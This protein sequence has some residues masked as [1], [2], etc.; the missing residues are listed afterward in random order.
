MDDTI[1]SAQRRA[2]KRYRERR[3]KSGL[4]RPEAQAPAREAAAIRKA[5]AILRERPTSAIK[6]RA[7]PGI[8]TEP[9]R[10]RSALDACAMNEPLS[11]QGEA[12]W[13][14]IMMRIERDRKDPVLNR[15]RDV[16]L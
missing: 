2:T 12:M 1:T 10:T 8:D 9:R 5:A 7:H 4:K 13:E 16:D 14:E 3:R 11:S 15:L 6:P